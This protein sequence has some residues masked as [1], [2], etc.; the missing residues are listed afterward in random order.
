M[1]CKLIVLALV[2]WGVVTYRPTFWPLLGILA[3]FYVFC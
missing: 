1:I 2:T 3:L